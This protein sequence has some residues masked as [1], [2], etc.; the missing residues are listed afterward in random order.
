[1]Y[2]AEEK[3]TVTLKKMVN[4]YYKIGKKRRRKTVIK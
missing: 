2:N 4:F 3:E 1:M